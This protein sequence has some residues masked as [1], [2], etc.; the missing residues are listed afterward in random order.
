MSNRVHNTFDGLYE[1]VKGDNDEF[2]S[3][4]EFQ[5]KVDE[6]VDANFIDT[7]LMD[8]STLYSARSG[9]KWSDFVHIDDGI[10]KLILLSLVE[11]PTTFFVLVNTQKGKSRISALEIKKWSEDV[12]K[13]VVTFV[14]VDNDKTLGDQSADS[15]I[16]TI[17]SENVELITLSSNSKTTSDIIKTKIDAYEFNDDYKMPV[18]VLL[19]NPKQIEKMLRLINY[20]ENKMNTRGSRLRH[21]EIWD[22]ADKTYS[23]YRDKI[24]TIGEQHVSYSKYVLEQNNSSYRLGFVTATDGDLLEEDY[25]ECANAHLYPVDILPEDQIH[26]R[27]LHHPESKTHRVPFPSRHTNNSYA[28]QIIEQNLHHFKTPITLPNGEMYFRKVIVNSNTKTE[29]MKIFA[30]WV[31]TND[32]YGFVFNGYCGASIKVHRPNMPVVI[33]KTK[34]KKFNETLFYIYKKL[35]LGDKPLVIIGRR[36]VDRGLGFHYCPRTNQVIRI[37]GVNGDLITRDREGLVWT[38]LILG[39][40]DDKNTATQKAGRLAGIIGNSPQY[41]GSTHYWT[42]EHTETLIRRHNTIVDAANTYLGCSVLQAVKHAEDNTPVVKV[43]HRVDPFSFLV[44]DNIEVV[45]DACKILFG[46]R[47]FKKPTKI[48]GFYETSLNKDSKKV[49]LLD[50]IKRVSIDYGTQSKDEEGEDITQRNNKHVKVT[51]GKYIGKFGILMN[52]TSEEINEEV[53]IKYNININKSLKDDIWES[54]PFEREEF[55]LITYRTFYPCYKNTEEP[56]SEHFVIKIR[57]GTDLNVLSNFK[58]QY[59]PII[60]PQE[61]NF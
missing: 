47:S 33:Y 37:E 25:P 48:N 41:P 31:N 43:N 30:K 5:Y 53:I 1:N 7:G 59:P 4:Y 51:S 3:E 36:K 46:P 28:T 23:Q 58:S 45:K 34:G 38:D 16:K 13:K 9:L 56:S 44:Y 10:K 52:K 12:T 49:S 35:N 57:P 54:I 50:A 11:N 61:G 18:I 24:F 40:I 26:Y 29:D 2:I 39:K 60:I 14:I 19:A 8:D 27:A 20:I 42:D 32:M 17:G 6:L 15:F 22:E 21:G 55:T